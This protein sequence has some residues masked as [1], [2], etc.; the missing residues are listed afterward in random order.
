MSSPW[1]SPALLWALFLV[2]L[3]LTLLASLRFDWLQVW[4]Q[5]QLRQATGAEAA[6]SAARADI[7]EVQRPGSL[8]AG[9]ETRLRRRPEPA[10]PVSRSIQAARAPTHR[11][12]GLWA[13]AATPHAGVQRSLFH[14]SGRRH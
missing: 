4:W 13:H 12:A 10:A 8:P 14:R 6:E 1:M 5:D 2:L 9:E 11:T 7:A 3:A